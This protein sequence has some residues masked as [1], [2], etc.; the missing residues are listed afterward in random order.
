MR[1]REIYRPKHFFGINNSLDAKKRYSGSPTFDPLPAK[2]IFLA[3][4]K[5]NF[6]GKKHRMS[7]S[8]T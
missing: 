7:C 1:D 2:G 6:G 3:A 8:A 5:F 4:R